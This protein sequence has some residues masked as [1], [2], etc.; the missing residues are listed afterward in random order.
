M[1]APQPPT[2]PPKRAGNWGSLAFVLLVGGG[3]ISFLLFAPLGRIG[4]AVMVGGMV[5]P[6]IIGL[7]YLVWG[8]WLRRAIERDQQEHDESV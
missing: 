6:A 5:F 3:F 8:R 1:N 2:P 4:T 7:H